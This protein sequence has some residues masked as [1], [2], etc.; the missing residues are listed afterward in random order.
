MNQNSVFNGVWTA[1]IT[2]FKDDLQID[3]AAFER[4][5]EHQSKGGVHGIVVSGTTGEG[6]TLSNQEKLALVK[7]ARSILPA[8]IR[9]M[10]G[11]GGNN[12]EQSVELSKLAEDAGADSLL[13]VTPPYNKPSPTGLLK[14]F[15]MISAATKIPLCLY[16]VP[17]R[18]GQ[19]LSVDTIARVLAMPHVGLMK[20]ATGDIAL[21]SRVLQQCSGKPILSGDDATWLASMAIG[22][23]GVISVFTNALPRPAVMLYDAFKRGDLAKARKIHDI[24]LP[25]MDIM[26][27]ESNPGPVKAAMEISGFAKDIL[28]APLAPVSSE[29]R[30]RIDTL[31]SQTKLALET[32]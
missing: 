9:V 27:C 17:G 19:M 28:R 13:I 24:L 31:L 22:G 3:W 4:I 6:P 2:P 14:H 20:E 18:T 11:T 16:H 12:T 8:S 15:E 5:L 10:A 21:Y 32:I 1:V 23:S 26:F 25:F 30:A 29:N 7:R